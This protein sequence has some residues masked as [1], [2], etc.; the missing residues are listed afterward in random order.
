MKVLKIHHS[1]GVPYTPLLELSLS[2][3]HL[4]ET[5]PIEDAVHLRSQL[6]M[7]KHDQK[8]M[9]IHPALKA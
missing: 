8:M 3:P 6:G 1:M 2:I 5:Q 9:S 7:N 4:L